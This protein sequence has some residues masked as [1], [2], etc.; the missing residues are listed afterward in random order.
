MDSPASCIIIVVLGV[1]DILSYWILLIR[2]FDFDLPKVTLNWW[3]ETVREWGA[4]HKLRNAMRRG[5]SR[6]RDVINIKQTKALTSCHFLLALGL[7]YVTTERIYLIVRN[8]S[9]FWTL[10]AIY[11]TLKFGLIPIIT[12]QRILPLKLLYPFDTLVSFMW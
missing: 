6:L 4:V 10:T 2:I 7:T 5:V 8:L 9:F 3:K 11:S 12:R 1:N